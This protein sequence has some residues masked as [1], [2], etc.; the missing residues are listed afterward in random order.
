MP[1]WTRFSTCKWRY[2]E[3]VGDRVSVVALSDDYASAKSLLISPVLFDEFF[4][5]RYERFC[6]MIKARTGGRAKI[7]LHSC[8]AVYDLID[9]FIAMGIDVLNPIQPTANGMAPGRLKDVFGRR[10]CFHGGIDSQYTLANGSADEIRRCV[11][12][13]IAIL[14]A[15][16]GYILAPSHHIQFTVPAEN[17]VALYETGRSRPSEHAVRS[18]GATRETTVCSRDARKIG[19]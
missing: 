16:G 19:P 14:G 4:K 5:P 10:I 9:R 8:G 17:V 6:A 3:E 12:D 18:G 11:E 15:D 1:C 13:V 7:L 2:L